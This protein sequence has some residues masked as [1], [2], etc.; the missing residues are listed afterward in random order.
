MAVQQADRAVDPPES[1]S[2]PPV[3]PTQPHRRALLRME[4]AAEIEHIEQRKAG[5]AES[6]FKAS[7]CLWNPEGLGQLAGAAVPGR[8]TSR[9]CLARYL[10]LSSVTSETAAER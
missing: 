5:K 8:V 7:T 3:L 9:G 6:S 2:C 10:P 1:W 4:P